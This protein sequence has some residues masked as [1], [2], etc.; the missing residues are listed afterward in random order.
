MADV[1]TSSPARGSTAPAHGLTPS[2]HAPTT[3]LPA[4]SAA[5]VAAML[6]TSLPVQVRAETPLLPRLAFLLISTA[7]LLGV[8]FTG[9]VHGLEGFP[10]VWRWVAFWSLALPTG[11]LAWRL[12]YLRRREE[13]LD[14]SRVAALHDALTGRVRVIGRFLAPLLLAGATAPLVVG[15]PAPWQSWTL[16][17]GGVALA[18]LV[19]RAHGS[20][21]AAIAGLALGAGLL[22]VWS[23][24]DSAGSGYLAA[25]RTAHLWAFAAWLGGALFN[26]AA[27]VPAGR[28]H[29][30]LDAVVAGARQL[31]RFRWVVRTSLP[32]IVL[33]GLWMALRYGGVLS[34]F[35]R[36][37]IGLLV[38]LK[39]GLIAA[40]VVIF[41]T[42]PLY[43]AC[44]PVRGVCDLNDLR[45]VRG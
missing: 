22:A 2:A 19:T 8:L 29:P 25:V 24:A 43:R 21:A 16:A 4:T 42:C 35:W 30:N 13:G 9:R 45:E 28:R 32:T 44:S 5:A 10:L 38:P 34:P 11:M 6:D 39:L 12:F 14:E 3:A 1:T 40:L 23:W 26:L 27:A 17:L 36:D 7:S 18:V 15:Y 20:R 33:T 41:I 31:E 37:G